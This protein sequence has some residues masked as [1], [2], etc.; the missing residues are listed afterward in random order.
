MWLQHT[1]R[2]GESGCLY[3]F[4]MMNRALIDAFLGIFFHFWL[5]HPLWWGFTTILPKWLNILLCYSWTFL[6]YRLYLHL[7]NSSLFLCISHIIFSLSLLSTYPY[8]ILRKI[9]KC[10]QNTTYSKSSCLG[11][12]DARAA[13]PIRSLGGETSRRLL[14]KVLRGAKSAQRVDRFIEQRDGRMDDE[15]CRGRFARHCVCKCAECLFEFQE[16]L[17]AK[18]FQENWFIFLAKPHY[19]LWV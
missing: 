2:K 10:F 16:T 6:T 9:N 4:E 8:Y 18:P 19:L 13:W 7:P 14:Q 12:T 15:I 3:K 17:K 5:S 1:F 11:S